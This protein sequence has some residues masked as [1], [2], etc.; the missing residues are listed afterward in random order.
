MAP[1][2]ELLWNVGL[3]L[4]VGVICLFI[5]AGLHDLYHRRMR[6]R[7]RELPQPEAWTS[8]Q[9]GEGPPERIREPRPVDKLD[10]WP[11]PPSDMRTHRLLHILWTKA[12]GTPGYDKHEWME[13]EKRIW[14]RR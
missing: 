6:Q 8:P 11:G 5:A 1:M 7:S 9:L 2:A 4:V 3:L 13:L 14:R 10:E 12:V